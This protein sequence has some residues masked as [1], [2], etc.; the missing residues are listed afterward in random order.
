MYKEID[1]R[2]KDNHGKQLAI[3]LSWKGYSAEDDPRVPTLKLSM[4]RTVR[5]SRGTVVP[6]DWKDTSNNNFT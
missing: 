2:C 6:P 1:Q 5:L 4:Y 3:L